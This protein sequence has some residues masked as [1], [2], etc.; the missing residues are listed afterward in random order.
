MEKHNNNN[1]HVK[2]KKNTFNKQ[3][4]KI[5]Y[6]SEKNN[7]FKKLKVEPIVVNRDYLKIIDEGEKKN[8][9]NNPN[10]RNINKNKDKSTLPE[11]S[12]STS[13]RSVTVL[14]DNPFKLDDNNE[15]L[16]KIQKEVSLKRIKKIDAKSKVRQYYSMIDESSGNKNKLTY[17]ETYVKLNKILDEQ[18]SNFDISKTKKIIDPPHN[19]NYGREERQNKLSLNIN[20]ARKALNN[21][22]EKKVKKEISNTIIEK[23]FNSQESGKL[24][25]KEDLLRNELSLMKKSKN[26]DYLREQQI[27]ENIK[28]IRLRDKKLSRERFITDS[29]DLNNYTDSM[30]KSKSM[31][32]KTLKQNTDE[33]Y[34]N[35]RSSIHYKFISELENI[36]NRAN[37]TMKDEY[38]KNIPDNVDINSERIEQETKQKNDLDKTYITD[39]KIV[40]D[41]AEIKKMRKNKLTIADYEAIGVSKESEKVYLD[42]KFSN[43]IYY[44]QNS[45]LAAINRLENFAISN[46]NQS[47]YK[48]MAVMQGNRSK[49]VKEIIEK[50]REY[51]LLQFQNKVKNQL[52]DKI[53]NEYSN[54]LD[55]LNQTID[56]LKEL[57]NRIENY[58]LKFIEYCKALDKRQ[59]NESIKVVTL[60]EIQS[61]LENKIQKYESKKII[62]RKN[63]GNYIDLRYFF[64]KL[65]FKILRLPIIDEFLWHDNLNNIDVEKIFFR[66]FN[67][68]SLEI[69][70]EESKSSDKISY[71]YELTINKNY[72][73]SFD[74]INNSRESLDEIKS[75]EKNRKSTNNLTNRGTKRVHES[76]KKTLL[77]TLNQKEQMKEKMIESIISNYIQKIKD[78]ELL[79]KNY[80]QYKDISHLLLKDI[81]TYTI[82]ND[83]NEVISEISSIERM[84]HELIKEKTTLDRELTGLKKEFILYHKDEIKNQENFQNDLILKQEHN[85]KLKQKN[86]NLKKILNSLKNPNHDFRKPKKNNEIVEIFDLSAINPYNYY[87]ELY[88][89]NNTPIKENESSSNIKKDNNIKKSKNIIINFVAYT[90]QFNFFNNYISPDYKFKTKQQEI[91][92]KIYHMYFMCRGFAHKYKNNLITDQEEL[93]INILLSSIKE[94]INNETQKDE[95]MFDLV[96]QLFILV[97]KT[98]VFFYEFENESS[99]INNKNIIQIKEKVEKVKK[100]EH[101]RSLIENRDKGIEKLKIKIQERL[102]RTDKIGNKKAYKK[103][104]FHRKI[105]DKKDDI[106]ENVGNEKLLS[107]LLKF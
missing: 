72:D 73:L 53:E 99:T 71:K 67:Y 6:N 39:I 91:N 88:N 63:L 13:K 102:K 65:K 52:K 35:K 16:F 46:E 80:N 68:Y 19:K 41:P 74:D 3:I 1:I 57:K 15:L 101:T 14:D 86:E 26:I 10:N 79:Y 42:P 56:Q 70:E 5:D 107:D 82:F 4:E 59:I 105:L 48:K 21:F 76:F 87:K 25:K 31:G 40:S 54:K 43:N 103:I 60:G 83:Y 66:V 78:N 84:M 85:K 77:D 49:S 30:K 50:T 62:I 96:C 32:F 23:A 47:L 18:A 8:T 2:N 9:I 51:K 81:R 93:S 29:I 33:Y 106:F 98:I 44:N 104:N 61:S 24:I 22:N 37:H 36:E 55:Y 17:N 90:K 11:I 20:E 34:K 64:I 92:S 95:L 38:Y 94:C 27:N 69:R 58:S 45:K 75:R 89:D 100:M 12:Y 7:N 28:A 97:E